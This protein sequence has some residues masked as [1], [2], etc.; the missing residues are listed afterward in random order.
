MLI[1]VLM[2]VMMLVCG[3]SGEC[4]SLSLTSRAHVEILLSTNP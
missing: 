1:T 2:V 3:D 4:S